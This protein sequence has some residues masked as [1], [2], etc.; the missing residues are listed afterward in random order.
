MK[1]GWS[2]AEFARAAAKPGQSVPCVDFVAE[3][4]QCPAC[5]AE[6]KVCK[7]RRRPVI[8]LAQGSFEAREVVKRCVADECAHVAR[9]EA[10]RRLV[11][12]RQRYGYDLIVYVGLA[13][14][15]AGKQRDEIRND[16]RQRLGI[17]LSAGTLSQLCDRFLVA[18]ECLHLLRAPYLRGAMQGGY[19]LHMDATCDR[20]KGG[21][22]VCLDGF[23]DWVLM[24]TRIDSEREEYLR[25]LV[26]RTVELFGDP[27]AIVRDL[28]DGGAGAVAKL[29]KRGIP[30]LVCHFHF[31]AAVGKH[32]VDKP[33]LMLRGL[34]RTSRVRADLRRLLR[35][36]RRYGAVSS[37][38]GRFGTGRVREDL[39]ALVL[40]LLE[41]DGHKDAAYPFAL[42]DLTFVRRCQRA[43]DQANQWVPV[44]RSQAERRALRHIN[45]LVHRLK[46]D[47]RFDQTVLQLDQVWKAFSELRDVLRLTHSESHRDPTSAAQTDLPL[48]ELQRLKEIQQT[49]TDYRDQ[50]VRQTAG[51]SRVAAKSNPEARILRYLNRYGTH[52]FGHPTLRDEQGDV[53]AVVERT[54]NVLETLFGHTKQRLRRRLG[55]AHLGRDLEQQPPQVMLATNLE[56]PDYV[57]VLC[58]SLDHLPEAFAELDSA[59]TGTGQL[60]RN[61]RDFALHRRVRELLNAQDE[62]GV[63]HQ[64]APASAPADL[65]ATVV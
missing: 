22:F 29:R 31:L 15:L 57:R 40:W 47:G 61:N 55:R 44:P 53:L 33:Y 18:L 32:L 9:S 60:L 37:Y 52:L 23:R 13:R 28:G 25:P 41:G 20:G 59:L 38:E 24:A 50:L 35:D 12:P 63:G 17:E 5:G 30:D 7:S 19:P 62:A 42:P 65:P 14:Y 39:S 54:N 6:L 4:E 64:T 43:L 27:I 3:A 36:L 16:L 58:G 51:L 34:I 26:D 49:V 56:H 1:A 2:G 21:L 46:R 48:L 11:K 10:L 8:T 45:G